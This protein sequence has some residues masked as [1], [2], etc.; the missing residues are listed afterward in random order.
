M[1]K[2]AYLK[3]FITYTSWP[4]NGTS[5]IKIAIIGKENVYNII[6]KGFNNL[7][8]REKAIE[9]VDKNEFLNSGKKNFHL[10]FIARTHQHLVHEVTKNI[11]EAPVLVVTES[12]QMN[13][14]LAHLHFIITSE[15]NVHFKINQKRYKSTGL[16]PDYVLLEYAY[17]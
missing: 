8:I 5:T 6:K 10:I 4:D 9:V 12:Q 11:L 14:N 3:Q 15:D 17:R 1:V 2:A 7:Q 13:K 16:I